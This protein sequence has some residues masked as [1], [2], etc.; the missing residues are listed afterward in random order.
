[1][2]SAAI[3]PLATA[4]NVCEGL[5]FESGVNKR[6]SE[7][8]IFYSLY[9]FLIVLGAGFVLIPGLP[10]L[11]L[12]LLSQVANGVLI[13]FVLVFMLKL[14]NRQRLMGDMRNGIWANVIA[15]STS[16]AMIVLTAVMLWNSFTG[17]Y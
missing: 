10:L 1:V 13:P 6:F 2:L 12:I 11:K 16:V 17:K 8:R 7:A 3:L 14:V 15:W 4:Y 5:G 9:T